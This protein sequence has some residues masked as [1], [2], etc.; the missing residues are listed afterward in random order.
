MCLFLEEVALGALLFVVLL[1]V[2]GYCIFP[3][4]PID[5]CGVNGMHH[6]G[7]LLHCSGKDAETH[8]RE[9]KPSV[10]WQKVSA[11]LPS[12]LLRSMSE[13]NKQTNPT[14]LNLETTA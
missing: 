13:T 12:L 3:L 7:V 10:F 6:S 14:K 5:S 8:K 1:L 2:K 4:I 9:D 11:D